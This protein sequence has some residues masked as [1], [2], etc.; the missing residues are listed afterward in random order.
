MMDE[1]EMRSDF[2]KTPL[3][4]I[5]FGG[6]SPSLLSPQEVAQW[7]EKISSLFSLQPNIEITLE[8]NPDD[9]TKPY[10]KD[11]RQAGINRISLGIQSF[12]ED[13]LQ[14]MNRLHTGIQARHALDLTA[15]FFDNFSLDLIYGI[16]ESTI[17]LWQE[18]I[19][20]ALQFSPKH[21][22][23]YALTVEP[24]T[25][26]AHQVKTGGISLLDDELVKD[27]FDFL[28]THLSQFQ[29]DHYEVSNFG[30]PGFYSVNNSNYWI[31]KPYLGIGPGAHSYDGKKTR[32]WNISNNQLYHKKIQ[33]GIFPQE[34][35]VLTQKELFN[36]FL[37]TRLRTQWG[38]SLHEI[39]LQFGT[40]FTDYLEE[41]V[42]KHLLAR[43]LYW[44]GDHLKVN[45]QAR[46]LS[47]GIASDLFLL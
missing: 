19:E 33:E 2:F 4:S 32:S 22:S 12:H 31:G 26:L 1:L 37:M 20:S 11:L 29:F 16:P 30:K 43:N 38:I 23:A 27:Q 41:Q 21:I 45:Q 3:E 36:E 14:F 44:D 35:E 47:D 6:G 9:A 17:E 42:T 18:D 25:V 13:Q 5:Y 15:N 10:F 40:H 39:K 46:F 28:V 34:V 7:L 24:Q 8:V